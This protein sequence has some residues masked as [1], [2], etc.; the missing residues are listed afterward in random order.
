MKWQEWRIYEDQ[1]LSTIES[2]LQNRFPSLDDGDF[3]DKIMDSCGSNEAGEFLW[4]GKVIFK[5]KSQLARIVGTTWSVDPDDEQFEE[6]LDFLE[7]IFKYGFVMAIT[8]SQEYLD[9]LPSIENQS[10]LK[11]V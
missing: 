6:Y 2:E 3:M 7:S 1:R 11:A 10:A 5:D 9:K 4:L 8:N